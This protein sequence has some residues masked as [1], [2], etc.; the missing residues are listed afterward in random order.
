MLTFSI[1]HNGSA[2]GWIKAEGTNFVW[3]TTRL[4]PGRNNHDGFLYEISTPR[5]SR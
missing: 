2:P 3:T 4:T 1:T 5:N